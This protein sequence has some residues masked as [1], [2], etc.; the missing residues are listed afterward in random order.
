MPKR[1]PSTH[2]PGL[3]GKTLWGRIDKPVSEQADCRQ[4]QYIRDHRERRK[5]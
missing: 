2:L 1:T 5:K 3:P 4:C